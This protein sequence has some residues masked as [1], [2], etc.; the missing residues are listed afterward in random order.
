VNFDE[1]QLRAAG[2]SAKQIAALQ[3]R[4]RGGTSGSRGYTYQRRYA[5][6]RATELARTNAAAT[7]G[8]EGLCP[9]DDVVVDAAAAHEHA[10]CKISRVETWGAHKKK[11]EREFMQQLR[12]L[13]AAGVAEAD[14]RLLL[15]VADAA[16]Q[17]HLSQRTP[18]PLRACTTV[19]HFPLPV[20]E[21]H[22]WR[23]PRF[24]AALDALLPPLLRGPSWRE[25]LF[26]ELQHAAGDPWQ[27]QLVI[28][29]INAAGRSPDVPLI[30]PIARSWS[31]T[32]ARWQEANTILA[33]I[34]GLSIDLTGDVCC[35]GPPPDTGFIARCDTPRFER[36]VN[37]VIATRPVTMEDFMR[38]LPR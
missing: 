1:A 7:I 9:V 13:R 18:P 12:L 20:P 37:D 6:L 22:P 36:F 26:K 3:Q 33:G 17:A 21:H 27:R 32:P 28:D 15:V 2:L 38:V 10:Q 11:L 24:A 23:V 14:V 4:Q 35:Y 5:L 30:F 34:P 25:T 29:L 31:V 8:M 16:R 19:E